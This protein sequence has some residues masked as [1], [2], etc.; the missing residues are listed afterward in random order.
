MLESLFAAMLIGLV[1]ASLAVSSSAFT[2][3]NAFGV[4]QSTAEFLIED[5]VRIA[6]LAEFVPM[7]SEQLAAQSAKIDALV[8]R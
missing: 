3:T 5:A 7:T 8:G 4:D 6:E 1:I 2:Q